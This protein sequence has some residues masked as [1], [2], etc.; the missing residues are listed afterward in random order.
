M[1]SI[2]YVAFYGKMFCLDEEGIT[3]DCRKKFHQLSLNIYSSG[4][5]KA[6]PQQAASSLPVLT[7]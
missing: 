5:C 4:S 6:V 1:E 3:V 7:C 2:K